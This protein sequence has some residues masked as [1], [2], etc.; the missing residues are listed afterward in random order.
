VTPLESTGVTLFILVLIVG[1]FLTVFSFPGTVIIAADAFLY[2]LLTGFTK[3][4]LGLLLL[5]ALISLLAEAVDFALGMAGAATLDFSSQ[6]AWAAIVAACLGAALL[7]PFL[8]GLGTF[9]GIFLGGFTGL[10][11]TELIHY[12]RMK[13][14][15]RPPVTAIFGRVTAA[16]VKGGAALS[17]IIVTLLTIYS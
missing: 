13:P 9:L 7:T 8:L 4:G 6:G 16:F 3:I 14:L 5:L 10:L 11:A 2:A 15:F 1:L 17:M 12:G